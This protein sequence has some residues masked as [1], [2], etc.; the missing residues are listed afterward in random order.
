[1][2]FNRHI[3][4][5]LGGGALLAASAAVLLAGCGGGSGYTP[6]TAVAATS[7]IS[8][9]DAAQKFSYPNATISSVTPVA[10]GTLTLPGIDTPMPEHCVIAG[11][12]NQRISPVDNKPYAISF[13]MRLPTNWNGRFFHQVNGGTDGTVVAAYGNILGGGPTTNGLQKGFA[14]ISSDAG[15]ATEST[16]GIGGGAFGVDPQARLD[17]GYQ[18]VGKLTPMAKNFIKTFYGKGPDTSYIV[19]TSNGGRHAM[20][21]ASRYADQY[22]GFLATSPGFNLPKAAVNQVWGAQ[23]FATISQIS[24]S[25]SRP[26]VRTSFSAA[27]MKAVGNGVL[28]KCDALDGVKDGSVNDYAAC[29]T[30][31]NISTDVATCTGTPDGTCLTAAQKTVLAKVMAGAKNSAGTALYNS[32]LWDAGLAGADWR[33]WKFDNATGPRDPIALAFIFT[34]PPQSTSVVT[35]TGNTVLDYA[36][37]FNVDTDAPKIFATDALYTESA[38]SFMTPPNVDTLPDLV[39]TNGRLLVLHGTSDPVFSAND[40]IQWYKRFQSNYGAQATDYA[41]L[42]IVPG[43]NHSRNGPATDQFD[44]V[45]AIVNWVEQG[46][47]PERIIAK[48]RGAGAVPTASV[49]AEVPATW[50][51]GRTR[52]LCLYPQVARYNGSGNIEEAASFNCQ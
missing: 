16:P 49:N 5:T 52:P 27:D 13:E 11:K 9:A 33:T 35:G 10:A 37:N 22:D 3:H 14:V 23:Q 38:M 24:S 31:F 42:F 34:T 43:M 17:Y 40:T 19:G 36:L 28:A 8:C 26:D 4:T 45:D 46:K 20:V 48:A 30:A 1:M 7:V 21:A 6:K 15:H 32:F 25:T 47:A 51:P 39:R 50:S 41:R 18:A 29:Q 2:Q 12:L 44:A